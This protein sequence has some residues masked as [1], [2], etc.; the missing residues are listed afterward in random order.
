[1]PQIRPIPAIQYRADAGA[2]LSAVIAPPYDVL[3]ADSK[4]ALL[5]QSEH[6]IATV[7]LPHLP[8]K[9]VGPDEVY[10][11]AEHPHQAQKPTV[12]KVA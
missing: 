12:M 11:G 10:A 9:T 4:A 8:A 6:N 7:D 5:A 2:D 3:D 1:M